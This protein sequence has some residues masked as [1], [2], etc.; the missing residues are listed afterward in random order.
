MAD[1]VDKNRRSV[2]MSRIKSH[3]TSPEQYVRRAVWKAGFRY[4]VNVRGLPGS[5]DLVLRKHNIAVLVQ[6]CFW[7]RHCCKRGKSFPA[8]NQELWAR[9]FDSNVARDAINQCKLQELGWQVIVIWECQ[10]RRDT[11]V[12]LAHLRHNTATERQDSH[13]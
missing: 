7:H 8:S 1:I 11:D 2:L 6:G 5:P 4:R 3:N 12:L 9:K 10:I 13:L